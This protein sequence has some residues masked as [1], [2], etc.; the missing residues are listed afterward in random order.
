MQVMPDIY[1]EFGLYMINIFRYLFLYSLISMICKYL[2]PPFYVVF[3]FF[4]VLSW[5]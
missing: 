3:V 2:I 4:N 5:K 1:S